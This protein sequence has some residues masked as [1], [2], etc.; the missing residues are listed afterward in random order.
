MNEIEIID[1][2]NICLSVV[3]SG[4]RSGCGRAAE[5]LTGRKITRLPPVPGPDR[6]EGL[7]SANS[8]D[9]PNVSDRQVNIRSGH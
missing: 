3:T 8:G 6:L 9:T 5:Y 2:N 1:Q 4:F 7:I